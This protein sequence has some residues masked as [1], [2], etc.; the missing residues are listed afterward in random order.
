[1]GLIGEHI[2]AASILSLGWRVSM[3]QQNSIDLLAFD[4]DTFLRIQCKASNPYLSKGRRQPSCHFQLG[5][6]GQKRRAT[7]EDYDIV[8]LVKPDT[9]C[10][11]FMPVTSVLQYKTKRVS[12][13][14]FT[15]ENEA[16]SW[17]KSVDVILEMRRLDG[18]VKVS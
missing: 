3:C 5:L 17:H 2:A 16:D 11:L 10:C 4:N 8:A 6:G 18:L 14:R 12:P 7:L 15:A 9:R 13:T 1:L